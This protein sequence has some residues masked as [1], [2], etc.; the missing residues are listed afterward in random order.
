MVVAVGG[1]VAAAV[2]DVNMNGDSRNVEREILLVMG[3]GVAVVGEQLVTRGTEDQMSMAMA[4]VMLQFEV[5]QGK[6]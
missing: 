2:V 1:A 4:M 3:E 5:G 6:D